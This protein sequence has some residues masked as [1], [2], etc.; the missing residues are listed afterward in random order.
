[1]INYFIKKKMEQQQD[2]YDYP[3]LQQEIQIQV[4]EPLTKEATLIKFTVYSVKGQDKLGTF[5]TYRRFSEFYA[6][7]EALNSRWPGCFVPSIPAKEL[8][9]T[10]QNVVENRARFLNSF[11]NQVAGLSHLFYSE[12]FQIFIRSKEH[13]VTKTFSQLKKLSYQEIL[14]KY[15]QIFPIQQEINHSQTNIKINTF[16][17]FLKKSIPQLESYK[18]Q[19]QQLYQMRQELN[20]NFID[21]NQNIIP[22]YEQC[23][24]NEYVAYD[25]NALIYSNQQNQEIQQFQNNFKESKNK[26]QFQYVLDMIVY[27][28]RDTQVFIDLIDQKAQ[29]E[30]SKQSFIKDIKSDEEDII[31]LCQGKKQQKLCLL[32]LKIKK[33][34]QNNRQKYKKMNQKVQ[35]NQ[36]KLLLILQD[37]LKSIDLG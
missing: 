5:D 37:L 10:N 9:S 1:T 11:C 26:N 20:N 36:S 7:K 16:Y 23:C 3:N 13:D 17:Q 29:L 27:E 14:Q 33:K 25:S 12:E 21:L 28:L 18:D 15:Q 19:I 34:N 8:N 6:L 35:T 2:Q 4:G 24:I 30:K 31:K 32:V 22:Q